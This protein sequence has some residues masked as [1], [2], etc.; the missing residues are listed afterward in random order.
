MSLTIHR[1]ND[2]D[3][4]LLV[5]QHW[6]IIDHILSCTNQ[7]KF[8]ILFLS[9]PDELDLR[10]RVWDSCLPLCIVPQVYHFPEFVVWCAK[11][12]SNESRPV[13]TEK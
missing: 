12:Y 9:Q 8:P 2:P 1:V 7:D 6:K 3:Q 11:H 5:D 13:V 4:N 10:F